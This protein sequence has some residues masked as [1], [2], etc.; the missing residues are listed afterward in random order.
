MPL[1]PATGVYYELHGQGAPLMIGLPLMASHQAIFGESQAAVLRGYLDR[2]ADRY[3]ILLVD[4][5]AI[6]KSRDILPEPMT[7]ER[8]CADLL[9]VASAAG[10][11]RFA[12]CGYS[13]SAAV[14]LQLA[15]RSDRLTALAIGGWPPIDAPYGALLAAS[16]AK[17]GQ[18]EPSSM[19]VLRSAEQ[20]VQWSQFYASLQGW[21]E[22]DAAA[23]IRCPRLVFFGGDGDLVEA[24]H[25]V[26]I[27]ST[28]RRCR[29]DLELTGWEVREFPGHGHEVTLQAA[30]VVPVIADFLD[31]ALVSAETGEFDSS[32]FRKN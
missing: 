10:F 13:W 25:P 27:A 17:I 26:P 20:Y 3:R 1:D 5:P 2:L 15:T 23:S 9:G 29:S 4:Y 16:L 31:R 18:V 21:G 24:G 30:L 19:V 32:R 8:V 6:G 12:Y 14:G 28:I 11:D 7:A 22:A